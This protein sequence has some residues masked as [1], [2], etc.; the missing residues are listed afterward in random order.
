MKLR[1]NIVLVW[2]YFEIFVERTLQSD[3]RIQSKEFN[4]LLIEHINLPYWS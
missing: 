1:F 4:V 2:Y 3:L